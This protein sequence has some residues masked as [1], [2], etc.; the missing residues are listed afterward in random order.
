MTGLLATVYRAADRSDCTNGGLTSKHNHVTLVVPGK[1]LG[2]FEPAPDRP[3]LF[4]KMWKPF[5][6]YPAFPIA[7]PEDI[8]G[9]FPLGGKWMFGGNFVHTSDGRLSEWCGN[10]RPGINAIP[11]Y[12]RAEF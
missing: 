12:D 7:V 3:A 9:D 2:P 5:G 11:V 4:L 8:P 1:E 10:D 6:L